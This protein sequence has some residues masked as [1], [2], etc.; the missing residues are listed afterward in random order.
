[1]ATERRRGAV[2]SESARLA[3][4]GAA[5]DIVTTRGYDHLSMEGIA[6]AAGVGKQTI[7]RWWSSKSELLADCLMEGMLLPDWIRVAN[8]GDLRADLGAWLAN[9]AGFLNEPGNANLARSII[10]AAAENESVALRLNERLGIFVL[11]GERALE[12]PELP[13]ALLG[14]VVLR[15]LRRGTID[16]AFARRLVE[17]IAVE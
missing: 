6:S 4:L 1:M 5:A 2:R 10:I 9:L 7:Y 13:E 16:E 15:L 14:A 12:S 17:L 3:I 8:S 11:F